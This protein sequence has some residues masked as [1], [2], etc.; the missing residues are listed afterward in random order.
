MMA[1]IDLAWMQSIMVQGYLFR[2]ILYQFMIVIQ[3]N[4]IF[5]YNLRKNIQ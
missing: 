3:K 5:K 2:K 1:K 4:I